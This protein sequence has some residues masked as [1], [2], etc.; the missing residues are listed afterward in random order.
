MKRI[1]PFYV[2]YNLSYTYT[3]SSCNDSLIIKFIFIFAKNLLSSRIKRIESF[4]KTI[5]CITAT[6]SNLSKLT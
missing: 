6:C 5:F 3:I 4:T 1:L 2:M